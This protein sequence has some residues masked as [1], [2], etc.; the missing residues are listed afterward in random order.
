S[1]W[2]DS[3]ASPRVPT[4]PAS[5]PRRR[6]SAKESISASWSTAAQ[7]D[8]VGLSSVLSCLLRSCR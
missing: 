5:S 7:Q 4:W 1:P 6:S 3:L 2:M 8:P